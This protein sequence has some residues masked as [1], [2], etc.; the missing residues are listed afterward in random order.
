MQIYH[1]ETFRSSQRSS[2]SYM[3]RQVDSLFY[4][5]LWNWLSMRR[6]KLEISRYKLQLH[7][8]YG[9]SE[10]LGRKRT[11]RA[12]AAAF[13][14]RSQG[15]YRNLRGRRNFQGA[16]HHISDEEE[17][18][19]H[20]VSKDSS[21]DERSLEVK[22]KRYKKRGGRSS[23]AS[24]ASDENDAETNQE[25]FGACSELIHCSEILAWGKGGM[26]NENEG[27]LDVRLMLVSLSEEDIPSLQQP[28]LC[29]RPTMEVKHL[30]QYVA[31]QTSIEEHQT[32][33]KIQET[34]GFNQRNLIL[35]YRRKSKNRT[36]HDEGKVAM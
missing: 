33:G 7:R 29:C 14:R 23:Q 3:F 18:G 2:V 26:R 27:K 9:D 17:D 22:P 11:A 24:A 12:T 32:L 4:V 34:C 5:S 36:D 15:S 1:C 25:S 10:A 30:S 16:E 21:A 20:D 8:H 28:Y 35:A 13:A 19:N 31:Q 6:R